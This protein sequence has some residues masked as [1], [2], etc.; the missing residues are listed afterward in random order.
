MTGFGM[1]IFFTNLSL[2]EFQARYL[3]LFLLLSVLP[4]FTW[5]GSCKN[6]QLILTS[7]KGP[8]LFLHFF[9]Y[10]LIIFL[11]ILSIILI[12]I[13]MIIL[14]SLSVIS[15]AFLLL[16]SVILL[17]NQIKLLIPQLIIKF[18]GSWLNKNTNNK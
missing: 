5:M 11:M 12:S 13:L 4:Y 2:M 7:L 6:I 8:F 15:V 9:Y 3:T 1:L 16:L 10:T 17:S 14:S 18:P